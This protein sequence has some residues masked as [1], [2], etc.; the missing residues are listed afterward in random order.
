M[1][2]YF[3]EVAYKGTIYAGSQVQTN[4]VTVQFELER[5]LKIFFRTPITLTGSS[6]TDAGVHA[7]QNYY[8]FDFERVIEYESIYNINAILPAD[9]VVKNIIPVKEAAHCRFDAIAREYEY[10]VY[11]QKNPFLDDRAYFFPYTLDK[12]KM[13]EAAKLVMNYTDFTS[14][15]KRNSQVKTRQCTIMMSEWIERGDCFVYHVKGNRFLR[16]MVRGLTGT[17]LQVGRGKITVDDFAAIIAAEDVAKADFS[18][19]GHGL[20]LTKVIYPEGYFTI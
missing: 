2:R 15:S 19:P 12:V 16:G 8:H 9:V 3:L 14:F 11:Q 17:M 20:F 13:Q 4:A 1:N 5:A 18:V 7:L 10:S 6:R